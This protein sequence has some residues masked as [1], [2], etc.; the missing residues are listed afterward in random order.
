MFL[1]KFCKIMV[2]NEE[3]AMFHHFDRVGI[4][5]FVPKMTTNEGV[6]NTI[7][8]IYDLKCQGGKHE[9]FFIFSCQRTI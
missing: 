1:G 9:R 3:E 8:R 7:M 5:C 4:H 2:S 6:Y